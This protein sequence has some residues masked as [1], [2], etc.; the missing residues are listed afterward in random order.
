[1]SVGDQYTFDKSTLVPVIPDGPFK[2]QILLNPIIK[3]VSMV[4]GICTTGTYSVYAVI[5]PTPSNW[6]NNYFKLYLI[7]YDNFST[8]LVGKTPNYPLPQPYIAAQGGFC[9]N[10][11]TFGSSTMQI[12]IT[13][14]Q[15]FTITVSG[16]MV[17]SHRSAFFLYGF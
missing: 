14:G 2:S 3:N 5:I 4:G 7:M 9:P 12:N 15:Y 6:N 16:G 17:S 1:M 8:N 11:Y 10:Y 13:N